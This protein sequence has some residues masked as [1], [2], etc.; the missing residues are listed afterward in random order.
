ME[1]G[2]LGFDYA[3]RIHLLFCCSDLT[4]GK[5]PLCTRDFCLDRQQLGLLLRARDTRNGILNSRAM[6]QVIL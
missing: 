5:L 4:D 6:K 3:F 1:H 2:R